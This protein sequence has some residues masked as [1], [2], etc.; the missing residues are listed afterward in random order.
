MTAISNIISAS[1]A[2][3][4]IELE[5][6]N[7]FGGTQINYYRGF[8]LFGIPIYWYGVIITVGVILAYLYAMWRTKDF[9]LSRD[10]VFDVVF[11]ALIGGFIGARAYYCI[12]ATAQGLHEYTFITAITEIRDGGL[13]IYGGIIAAL[14]VGAVMCKIRKVKLAPMFDLAALGFLIGQCIGRWGNFV[15]QEAYGGA[16][17]PDYIFGMSGT[18]IQ[19]SSGFEGGTLV[20]PCFLYESVWCLLGFIGLHFYS[21]KLRTYDGEVFLLYIAWYGL[22]RAFIEG[23]RTDSL[24]AGELRIS[25]I[26]AGASFVVALVLFIVFKIL[27]E[28]KQIPLYVNTEACA[29]LLAADKAKDEERARKKAAKENEVAQSILADDADDVT[30][31]DDS[32]EEEQENSENE[33]ENNA[34]DNSDSENNE[35]EKDDESED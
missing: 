6:P 10:R 14:I 2:F 34:D 26:I 7:L 32:E 29:E 18:I 20:H 17:S 19:N 4:E 13:A 1:S 33:T 35:T 27:A 24:M 22:G 21:K 28:K 25:Q 30:L 3:E 15:N 8:E 5:F 31:E 16:T 9:G 11:A 23:M 12:F